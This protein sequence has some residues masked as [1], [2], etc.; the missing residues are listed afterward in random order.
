MMS[1]AVLFRL[2]QLLMGLA[3]YGIAV[4][5][6][7]RAAVGLDPWD[8]FAQG[9]ATKSGLSF[10]LVT[11]LVGAAVLLLW[12]PLRQRPGLGTLLNVLTVGTMAQVAIDLVPTPDGLFP[13]WALFLAG[14][15]LLAVA[16]GIYVGA[17][18]GPG[19]RDG[20]MTGLSKRLGWPI[21]VSRTLI[22]G[23]VLLLGWLLGGNIGWGTVVFA[24]LIGPLCHVTIPLFARLV[25]AHPAAVQPGEPDVR[26]TD[27]TT[28]VRTRS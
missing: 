8:T 1:R 3:L 14:V 6:M 11:N 10:G 4:G 2:L 17:G 9:I 19:P 18:M 21:W 5:L 7:V 23:S 26:E 25:P 22:E 15:V 28:P 16:T 13:R 27:P 20:L 24:V 12:I